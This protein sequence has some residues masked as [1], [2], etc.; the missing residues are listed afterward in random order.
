MLQ[1]IRTRRR[2]SSASGLT[3][4]PTPHMSVLGFLDDPAVTLCLGRDALRPI[5][6]PWTIIRARIDPRIRSAPRSQSDL[7][8]WSSSDAFA[9]STTAFAPPDPSRRSETVQSTSRCSELARLCHPFF[10]NGM[11]RAHRPTGFLSARISERLVCSSARVV[12][13]TSWAPGSWLVIVDTV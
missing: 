2:P 4:D 6:L 12:D 11:I 9:I 3:S 10:P 1:F 5:A 13:S 7:Y 8:L